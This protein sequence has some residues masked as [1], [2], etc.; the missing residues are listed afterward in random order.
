ML[1]RICGD[2]NSAT[3]LYIACYGGNIECVRILIKYG[4]RLTCEGDYNPLCMASRKNRLDIIKLLIES[5]MDVNISTSKH[6]SALYEAAIGGHV[7]IVKYLIDRGADT[8]FV[9]GKIASV[10][11]KEILGLLRSIRFEFR[12]GMI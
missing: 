6:P 1:D 8:K 7:N 12:Q 9:I 3:P 11:N 4:V 10:K 2:N 5:G